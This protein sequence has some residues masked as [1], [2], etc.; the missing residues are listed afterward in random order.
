MCDGDANDA[1][2]VTKVL[3][4]GVKA[5]FGSIHVGEEVCQF[6]RDGS[7][8][9][10]VICKNQ[11]YFKEESDPHF[12]ADDDDEEDIID[13][14]GAE[15]RRSLRGAS[16]LGKNATF[17]WKPNGSRRVSRR[18]LVYDDSGKNLDLMVL[19][20]KKAECLQSDLPAGC[21][22]SHV[23]EDNML[24]LIDLAV[25]ETNTAFSLSGVDT[26]IR[27]V[28]AYRDE[29]YVEAKKKA[30]DVAVDH[31]RNTDDDQLE[32]AHT[33]RAL[34]GAGEFEPS[35]GVPIDFIF[36]V[37]NHFSQTWSV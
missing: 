14:D 2:F 7:G 28:H 6:S 36:R 23:T 19:W 8:K 20:T 24:A 26:Q 5:V 21:E 31:L 29:S 4:S 12:A 9:S 37:S 1:T 25:E 30:T 11:K 27:L 16:V 17:G 13:E 33:K 22:L 34:Y 15:Q 35:Y 18:R 10:E 3:P 32:D